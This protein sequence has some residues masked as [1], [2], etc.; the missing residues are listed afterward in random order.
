MSGVPRNFLIDGYAQVNIDAV[1]LARPRSGEEGRV[2]AGMIS[3]AVVSG[4][5]IPL[6]HPANDLD[7]LPYR[8]ERFHGPVQLEI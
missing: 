5:G 8:L 2:G 7:M 3:K 4:R 1:G 6:I